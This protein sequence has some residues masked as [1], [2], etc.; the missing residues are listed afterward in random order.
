MYIIYKHTA[1]DGRVYIGCTGVSLKAR[2][3]LGYSRTP[4]G[5]IVETVGWENI[6]STILATTV[7][8]N[9]SER[10]EELYIQKCKSRNPRYGFNVARGTGALPDSQRKHLSEAS[11]LVHQRPGMHE[12]YSK[13]H[14]EALQNPELR[15]LISEQT[16]IAMNQPYMKS[17]MSKATTE[18]WKDPDKRKHMA[19]SH[20]GTR[21]MYKG[22]VQAQVIKDKI[23]QYLA[24]GWQFGRLYSKQSDKP[25]DYDLL[26]SNV[27]TPKTSE[28]TNSVPDSDL[29]IRKREEQLACKYKRVISLKRR[30]STNE[31]T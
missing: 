21:W 12:K 20:I 13:G 6:K 18:A 26:K 4:F 11:K 8:R 2:K 16:K 25:T 7:D 31:V 17:Y 22:V 14:K 1:P 3:Q 19:E 27:T 23:D 30:D 9:E 5:R 29:L 28:Q 10:L 15:Q 24:E